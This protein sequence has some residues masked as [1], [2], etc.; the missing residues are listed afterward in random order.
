MIDLASSSDSIKHCARSTWKELEDLYL[1]EKAVQPDRE[2]S[3]YREVRGQKPDI[4][5]HMSI[6]S[7]LRILRLG[8]GKSRRPLRL[9]PK[10][11]HAQ[12]YFSG[13]LLKKMSDCWLRIGICS[14][15][16]PTTPSR[17]TK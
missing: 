1:K 9:D 6:L 7:D 4:H 8:K 2:G 16:E 13:L 15:M 10:I 3:L 12:Y 17:Y 11:D 14:W 5:K